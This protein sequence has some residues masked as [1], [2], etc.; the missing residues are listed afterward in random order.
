MT[1]KLQRVPR[2]PNWPVA[3]VVVTAIWA[4]V[5]ALTALLGAWSHH[6]VLLCPFRRLTGLPCPGCG[7]TR[8][9]LS[10]IHGDPLGALVWNPLI[11]VALCLFAASLLLRVAAG[12]KLEFHLGPR[13]NR[14]VLAGVIGLL[15]AN[16]TYVLIC[17]H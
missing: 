15:A 17:V 9:V 8:A 1:L 10:M 2:R 13:H 16:W 3:P 6:E 12:R 4:G 5:V 7:S 11:T 14:I